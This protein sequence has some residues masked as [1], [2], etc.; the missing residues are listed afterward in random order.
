MLAVG[1]IRRWKDYS[2]NGDFCIEGFR[3][4]VAIYRYVSGLYANRVFQYDSEFIER[5]SE[6]SP[7]YRSTQA[8]E[9][10]SDAAY[11]YINDL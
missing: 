1:Q 10:I 5:E 2:E 6:L 4:E 7:N 8:I 3:G 9:S 11:D